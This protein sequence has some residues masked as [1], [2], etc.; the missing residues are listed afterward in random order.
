MTDV[1]E[2]ENSTRTIVLARH[3]QTTL[4]ADGRLRGRLDPDLDEVGIAEVSALSIA[5]AGMEVNLVIASPL[6]R[7]VATA[8]AIAHRHDASV[9]TDERLIDRDYGP[10]NGHPRAD[11]IAQFGSVDDAPGVEPAQSVLARARTVL[12][13]QLDPIAERGVVLVA[14]DAINRLLI[15]ALTPAYGPAD[16]IPQRTACF[17]VLTHEQGQWNV[18][19]VDQK[20]GLDDIAPDE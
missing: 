10:W 2:D 12:D 15:A 3:G 13:E 5:L 8:Q 6:R 17:N 20:L 14:H 9:I 18:S 4:N 19:A 11:V 7:A 1:R 16:D